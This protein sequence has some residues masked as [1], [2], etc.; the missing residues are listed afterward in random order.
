[1]IQALAFRAKRERDWRIM[2]TEI[3]HGARPF[4]IPLERIAALPG[5][6]KNQYAAKARRV[7]GSVAKT[8]V[9][10]LRSVPS[11]AGSRRDSHLLALIH[12]G[13]DQPR[14]AAASRR[15]GVIPPNSRQAWLRPA[16]MT[17]S[18]RLE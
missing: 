7:L 5:R 15:G 12:P 17:A 13:W 9:S 3:P 6:I 14:R 16:E 8:R 18:G 11:P 10:V 1:M 2:R 4:S